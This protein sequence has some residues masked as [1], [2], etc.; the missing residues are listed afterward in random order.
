[1]VYNFKA[2]YNYTSSEGHRLWS[3]G[4][5]FDNWTNTNSFDDSEVAAFYNRGNYGSGHGWSAAHSV[6]WGGTVTGL[7]H[8]CVQKPP[9]AQN[10][11]IG[12]MADVSGSGP[13][14]G[15]NGYIEGAGKAGINPASLYQA[16]LNERISKVNTSVAGIK[17]N[18]GKPMC[19]IFPNPF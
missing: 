8:F 11:A 9:T 13:F 18:T 6:I 7:G 16:Q 17:S 15:A 3:Q 19:K 12:C 2:D 4:I 1:M 5:L 14:A 10:Y